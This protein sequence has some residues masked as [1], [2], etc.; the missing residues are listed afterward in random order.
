[1]H[2][3]QPESGGVYPQIYKA[4]SIPLSPSSDGYDWKNIQIMRP[5]EQKT[6]IH[7]STINLFN[8]IHFLIQSRNV[9]VKQKCFVP[10]AHW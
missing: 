5:I 10:I 9:Y 8:V 3:V 6:E 2:V 7:N 1:M 4:G